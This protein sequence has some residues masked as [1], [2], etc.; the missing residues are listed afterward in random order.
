[1]KYVIIVD[2][3]GEMPYEAA[4]YDTREEAKRHLPEFADLGHCFV[5]RV[6]RPS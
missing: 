4:E 3:V 2:P 1:M 5:R 6:R